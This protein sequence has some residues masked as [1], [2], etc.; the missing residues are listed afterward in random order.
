MMRIFMILY[1]VAGLCLNHIGSS[2]I[3]DNRKAEN[4]VS[5]HVA[6][7][8]FILFWPLCLLL[9]FGGNDDED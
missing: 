8:I 9:I 2:K 7:I 1:F 4:P 3:E 6:Q 5:F